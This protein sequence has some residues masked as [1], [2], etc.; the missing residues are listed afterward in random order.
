METASIR[1]SQVAFIGLARLP[2]EKAATRGMPQSTF[3]DQAQPAV[4]P[5]SVG[6][7]SGGAGLYR[8]AAANSASF[9]V[10]SR[11]SSA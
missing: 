9:G 7:Q 4:T 11:R 1:G 10:L 6:L 3:I 5:A 8:P 2:M